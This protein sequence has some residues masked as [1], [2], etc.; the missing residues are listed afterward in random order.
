MG[1]CITTPRELGSM[2]V[3]HQE[4]LAPFLLT[5][6]RLKT[7]TGAGKREISHFHQIRNEGRFAAGRETDSE[8]SKRKG[9]DEEEGLASRETNV[10]SAPM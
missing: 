4:E 8:R 5:I 10:K 9:G 6:V 7:R 1:A 3:A 2:D